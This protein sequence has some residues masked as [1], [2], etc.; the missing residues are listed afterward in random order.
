[1]R[2]RHGIL[3]CLSI[4]AAISH[5]GLA[6]AQGGANSIVDARQGELDILTRDIELTETRKAELRHEIASLETDR[7]TLN[8]SL[9]DGSREVQR[10][11]GAID[12]SERRLRSLLSDEDRLRA[13][14]LE[15]QLV[16]TEVLAALQRLGYRAPPVLVVRPEDALASVRSAILLGAVIPGL[17]ERADELA[18]DLSRLVALRQAQERERDRLRADALAL[19]EGRTRIA[20]LL[21]Q[22]RFQRTASLEALQIEERRAQ[23]LASQ[24]TDLRELIRRIETENATAA[25]ASAAAD[26][27][28]RIARSQSGG[29]P[30]RSLGSVDRLTPSVAFGDAK[31]LLPLPANGRQIT[32]FGS[33]DGLGGV[34]QGVSL[35]TRPGAQISSPTDGWVVYAGPFRSYGRLLIVNA[36]DDYHVLL[37]GMARIDVQLG[38][39]VLAGEPVGEMAIQRLASLGASGIGAGQPVLYIEFRR[40]GV[41]IDPTPWWAGSS[42]EKVGG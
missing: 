20:L 23:T 31:G 7:A 28:G 29:R 26:R 6:S 39:F 34:A 12:V 19:I 25:A 37:A 10:L 27:A 9:I 13:S 42:T 11:E 16:L 15:R 30:A 22:K 17:R 35:E 2:N 5:G 24:V 18:V 21:E 33:D 4:L 14:L 3:V 36:G 1:M 40:D 32:T 8:Q 38:Q 41:S